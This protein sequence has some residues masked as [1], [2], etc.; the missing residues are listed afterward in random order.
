MIRTFHYTLRCKK[1]IRTSPDIWWRVFH[2]LTQIDG[3]AEPVSMHTA[4]WDRA[5]LFRRF[6]DTNVY[7]IGSVKIRKTR[8]EISQEVGKE[9]EEFLFQL[10]DIRI[11]VQWCTLISRS[12]QYRSDEEQ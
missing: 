12:R 1:N 7:E 3:I 10:V 9:A 4:M 11:F 6:T 2:I 8:H 5:S